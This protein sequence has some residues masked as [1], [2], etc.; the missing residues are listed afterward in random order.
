MTV[1]LAQELPPVDVTVE[2]S[3]DPVSLVVSLLAVTIAA[4]SFVVTWRQGQAIRNIEIREHEWQAVDRMSAHIEVT[5]MRESV[6]DAFE[7]SAKYHRRNWIR[8]RNTGR[9]RAENIVWS[10]IPGASGREVLNVERRNLDELHPGEHFDLMLVIVIA[11]PPECDFS[12]S[13][14]DGNGRHTTSRVINL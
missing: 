7:G 6:P 11:D 1:L 4:A 13:W 5:R 9:A 2:T 8:L 10:D 3:T 12:V 14:S